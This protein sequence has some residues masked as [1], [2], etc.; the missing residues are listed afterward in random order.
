VVQ[1]VLHAPKDGRILPAVRAIVDSGADQ[2]LFPMVYMT[3]LG[4]EIADC[5][6][7]DDGQGAGG[8]TTYYYWPHGKIKARVGTWKMEL[9]AWFSATKVPLLGREDFFAMFSS[10]TFD[11]RTRTFTINE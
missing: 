6:E 4:I 3:P 10:I 5:Q 8:T 7:I 1:L 11:Q 9:A 2:S